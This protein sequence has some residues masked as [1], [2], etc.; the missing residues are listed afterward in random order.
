MVIII[1]AI[2][3]VLIAIGLAIVN[4]SFDEFKSSYKKQLNNYCSYITTNDLIKQVGKKIKCPFNI[5]PIDLELGDSYSP[6]NNTLKIYKGNISNS[7]LASLTVI[8]H[9]LGHAIQCYSS[10]VK[11]KKYFRKVV[12]SSILSNL[13]LPLFLAFVV[14]LCLDLLIFSFIT[15]GLS[16]FCFIFS[17][18]LKLSTIKIEKEASNYALMI[19][20]EVA[21]FDDEELKQSEILLDNAKNTYVAD[22]LKS[23]LKWTFLTRR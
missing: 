10:P 20:K 5:I 8:A 23:L 15:L 9:E 22:F 21:Y 13:C 2:F 18:S 1:V 6:Y 3:L 7:S 16:V 14:L 17:L 12:T 11:M 4:Y 19:L